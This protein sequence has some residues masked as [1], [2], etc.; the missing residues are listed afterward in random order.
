[1]KTYK[2]A[3][4]EDVKKIGFKEVKKREPEDR[5]VLVKVDSCAICTLEQRVYNGVMNRYPF[6][7]GHEAAGT[8]EAIGKK[9]KGVQVG[10]K[11]AVRLLNSCGECYYC[12]NGH[13]NQCTTSFIA[14]TQECA[15][16][17]G[18]FAEYM[19]MDASDVYKMDPEIDL[20][21]AALSEPL[22]CCVHSIENGR[23][24]LGDDV[25]VIGVGIMGA[26]HIQLAKLKGA[27]VIACEL[28]DTR[29]EIAKKMGA[30]ILINSGKTDP[31]KEIQKLTEGRGADAV[32]CTVPVAALAKQ[33]VDMSGKLGRVVFYTSFH[34]DNPIE[35]SPNKVHSTEQIITGTVN[36]MKK[37]FLIATRLLSGKLIDVSA[38]ISDCIPLENIEEAMKKAIRPDT[39]RIIVRP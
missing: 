28:D 17:P 4:I 26:L 37:D 10:D 5:Q 39:Y 36:P 24:G 38:L 21:H 22:A 14:E 7:G 25:V 23:V 2:V 11:V 16:G 3:V 6:A 34:P 12:R 9:V 35:I 29:L 30:D 27:R 18:G 33:A 20:T 8:V 19:M 32:F 31:V 13:E 1:M 15:M